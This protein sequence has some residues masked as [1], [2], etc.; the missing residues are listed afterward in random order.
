ML[1]GHMA[2]TGYRNIGESKT[3]R[4]NCVDGSYVLITMEG[5]KHFHSNYNSA[6]TPIAELDYLARYRV[7]ESFFHI[8]FWNNSLKFSSKGSDFMNMLA[9]LREFASE[10]FA[11]FCYILAEKW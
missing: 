4:L 2:E 6:F 11:S 1:N 10:I 8:L 5:F 3:N 7:L 9:K